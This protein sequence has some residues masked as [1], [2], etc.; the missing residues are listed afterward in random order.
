[1]KEHVRV[2][3]YLTI[4]VHIL[5]SLKSLVSDLRFIVASHVPYQHVC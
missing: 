2:F 1:M 3:Y 5:G 4:K